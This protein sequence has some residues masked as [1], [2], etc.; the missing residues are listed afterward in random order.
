MLGNPIFELAMANDLINIINI[1]KPHKVVAA[2]EDGKQVS[3]SILEEICEA[4]VVFLRRCEEYFLSTYSPP[5]GTNSVGAHIALEIDLYLKSQPEEDKKVKQ[6]MF[7]CL[8]KRETCISG[9]DN[10]NEI[11]LLEMGSYTELQGGNV[12]LPDGYSSI[13][14]P[15]LQPLPKEKLLLQHVV[16]KVK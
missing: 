16:N 2:L 15:L 6:L 13:L 5:E 1:P 7:D 11:D 9:C 8:L 3:F 12:T 14:D 10:M 4:Y